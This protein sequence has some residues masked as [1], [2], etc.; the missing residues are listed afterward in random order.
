MRK[1]V[2]FILC[3]VFSGSVSSQTP[4][5]QAKGR[6][7]I[8][9]DGN[10]H[11]HDDWAATPLS[12]ALLAAKGLQN[13]LV[14]YTYSDHVW[15]SNLQVPVGKGGLT[16]YEQMKESALTGA[17]MFGFRKSNFICAVDN[18][19]KAYNEMAKVINESSEDNPLFIVAAGPMQ[20][21]GEG[22]RRSN[23]DKR[24]Y[25]TVISHSKWNDNHA[26]NSYSWEP[27]HKGWTFKM[28]QENFSSKK[29]GQVQFVKIADQN[30]G[31]DYLGLN[32]S[33][34]HFDWM[35]ISS[36]K[37][38]RLY[39]KGSWDWLYSRQETCIKKGGKNFD[40]SDAGMVIYLL[41]GIEKT[42]SE[43]AKEIMENPVPKLK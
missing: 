16:A 25:V 7:A 1:V 24:K 39:K 41:T 38:N 19:E 2:L 30:G 43:L 23:R 31:K 17:K 22:I 28:M 42:N 15:G 32:C 9:S 8:S 5:W 11:D 34:D 18:P 10:E 20:V 12:L 6:I 3:I 4:L 36:A 35:K 14:L 13:K 33:I 40:P 26:A 21:V 27:E 37:E 29:G